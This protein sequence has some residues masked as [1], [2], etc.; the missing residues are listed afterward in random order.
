MEQNDLLRHVLDVLNAKN[1]KYM[2]VGSLASGAYGEPRMTRDI[3]I[4]IELR[5]DELDALLSEFPSPDYYF[6]RS[7]AEEAVR[8]RRQ[9]NVLH[10]PSGSK[11][12]FILVRE[13]E[14]GRTQMARRR[15]APV[16]TDRIGYAASPE[17]VILGKLWY[18]DI[19]QSD[20]HLRDIAGMLQVMGQ[21]IDIAYIDQWAL[22]L[23][24]NQVWAAVKEKAGL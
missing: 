11:V 5:G 12:H 3:D 20:K 1:V 16:L 15:E 13:D 9:F 6:D 21:D 17:D 8:F 2:L 24:Y 7:T 18:Y 23:G 14:W 19:G 10:F 22:Q 4:V